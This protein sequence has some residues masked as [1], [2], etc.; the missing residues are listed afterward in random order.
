MKRQR[1]SSDFRRTFLGSLVVV[2]LV[3]IGRPSILHAGDDC[4]PLNGFAESLP[5]LVHDFCVQFNPTPAMGSDYDE[6][7]VSATDAVVTRDHADVYWSRYVSDF[8]FLPPAVFNPG[9]TYHVK[10]NGGWG[11]CNGSAGTGAATIDAT[12]YLVPESLQKVVGH[13][14]FHSIQKSY[15]ISFNYQTWLGEGTARALEDNLFDNIDNWPEALDGNVASSFN[16]QVNEYLACTNYD[17]TVT[18]NGYAAALWWKYFSEQFGT[19]PGEPQLG[20]DAFV[21]LFEAVAVA[22][23]VA[24]VNLALN[25]LGAGTDFH[26]AFRRFTVANVTKDL[27]NLPDSSYFYVDELQAGNPAPYGPLTI[28]DGGAVPHNGSVSMLDTF[29]SLGTVCY[30]TTIESDEELAVSRYG[31]IYF[32]AEPGANCDI[33][34][35]TFEN[36]DGGPAFY[37]V[38]TRDGAALDRHVEGGGATW[39]QSFVSGGITDAVAI[40]GSLGAS[41]LVDVTFSCAEADLAV[42]LPTSDAVA[43]VGPFDQPGNLLVQVQVT[44]G[45]PDGPIVGGFSKDDFG[46]KIG[47]IDA[48]VVG[49]GFVSEQYWLVVAAPEQPGNGLYNLQVRLENPGSNQPL[50]IDLQQN[51]VSYSDDATDH[52]LVVDRSG[53]MAGANKLDAAQAAAKLYVDAMRTGDGIAV[54]PYNHNVSPAPDDMELVDPLARLQAKIFV[55]NLVPA[56]ATSIGDGLAEAV[57]QVNGSPTGNPLCSIVLLS[58][59]LENSPLYWEDV[60]EDVTDSDCPVTA[61]AFGVAADETLMQEIAAAT[62]GA[63]Y[64]NDVMISSE[65]HVALALA[66]AFAYAQSESEGHRRLFSATGAL[67]GAEQTHKVIVDKTV[68]E[69]QFVLDWVDP[70]SPLAL[71]LEKPDGTVLDS[72]ILPYTFFDAQSAHL[73]WRIA[74]PEPGVWKLTVSAASPSQLDVAYQVFATGKSPLAG[75]LLLPDRTQARPAAGEVMPIAAIVAGRTPRAGAQVEATVVAPDGSATLLELHD[76]GLHGDGGAGDGLYANS[77]TRATQAPA[78]AAEGEGGTHEHGGAPPPSQGAYR[79]FLRVDGGSF[80]REALGSFAVTAT[81]DRDANGLADGFEAAYGVNDP[82]G[83]PDLDGLLTIEEFDLGTS[84]VDSDTD[85]GGEH[86]GS[87]FWNGADP[88][89]ASDDAIE[90]PEFFYASPESEAVRL[91]YDVK[92][93]YA[94]VRI[95]RSF[96]RDGPWELV[97]DNSPSS[98]RHVERSPDGAEVFFRLIA[99]SDA[100]RS[101]R[102]VASDGVTPRAD[103]TPPAA[104]VRIDGGAVY[105]CSRNVE[106]SFAAKEHLELSKD[107][108]EVIVS[109]DAH[110]QDAAFLPFAPELKWDLGPRQDDELVTLYVVLRDRAGN[111]SGVETA[112]IRYRPSECTKR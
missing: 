82:F 25:E 7:Q 80:R 97:G 108:A 42:R 9:D 35:V 110:F 67:A 54:V 17:L 37:H 31:A 14:L 24:A 32:R 105:T 101:S 53:S 85:G 36:L 77:Y 18:S 86:D 63:S 112:T 96:D 65:D 20:I 95:Y 64:F 102:V 84:P 87:E 99:L 57:A 74:G 39:T 27:T 28:Y 11:H 61:I 78:V 92:A 10:L 30:E 111:A 106:L 76:D 2:V 44:D 6:G 22:D 26:T 89:D 45:A 93:N 75:W 73:G 81:E 8:G 98:G 56:G 47:G 43:H 62:G 33:L 52:V 90:A 100:G 72:G 5:G 69:L 83:D 13:E 51:S 1:S 94:S 38:V 48:A 41:S 50:A 68:G 70:T 19:T 21:E 104:Q 34:R 59:G 79:V 40:A 58:D 15:D 3:A 46:V 88:L 60:E 16:K 103:A 91:H 23:D 66:D 12:C 4:P 71:R 107:I 109:N 49:G 29:N 55:N